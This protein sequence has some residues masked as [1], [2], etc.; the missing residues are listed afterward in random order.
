MVDAGDRVL[1]AIDEAEEDQD[2]HLQVNVE[3]VGIEVLQAQ[4]PH[5]KQASA[6]GGVAMEDLN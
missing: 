2:F 6:K 5:G 1:Q 3:V 4:Y